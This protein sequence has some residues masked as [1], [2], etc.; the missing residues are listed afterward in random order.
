MAISKTLEYFKDSPYN[1]IDIHTDSMSSVMAAAAL[2]PRSPIIKNI[3]NYCI[4]V[5]NKT[6]RLYWIKAHAGI[7]GNEVADSIAGAA[8]EIVRGLWPRWFF[9]ARPLAAALLGGGWS[10]PAPLG[11]GGLNPCGGR[12]FGFS[13]PYLL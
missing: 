11:L 9:C 3:R 5:P 10:P 8:A 2:Y 6:I 13:C 12:V 1:S 7:F 4:E